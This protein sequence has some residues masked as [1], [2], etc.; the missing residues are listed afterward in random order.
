MAKNN[1]LTDFLINTANAIRTVEGSTDVINPQ[2]FEDRIKNLSGLPNGKKWTK[3]NIAGNIKGYVHGLWFLTNTIGLH[4]SIDGRNWF[5]ATDNSGA[6]LNITIY[7][8]S[9]FSGIFF[10]IASTGVYRSED[11]KSNWELNYSRTISSSVSPMTRGGSLIAFKDGSSFFYSSRDGNGETDWEMITDHISS[12]NTLIYYDG[13]W[14]SGFSYLDYQ[15]I[16][17]PIP[18]DYFNDDVSKFLVLNG[19][20]IAATYG[21]YG[22]QDYD[23][24]YYTTNILS[25]FTEKTFYADGFMECP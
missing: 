13:Y 3:G 19:L 15:K 25:G 1:N 7:D 9:Y 6:V 23:S 5:T 16:W 8:I 2:D 18:G 22:S 20:L 24:I 17:Q 10:I 14:V 21:H 11:G 12:S 4:Y